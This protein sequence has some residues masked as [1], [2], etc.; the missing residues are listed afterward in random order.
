MSYSFLYYGII[1]GSWTSFGKLISS[2]SF[3]FYV[4]DTF[5][6]GKYGVAGVSGF[7]WTWD[8]M[9]DEAW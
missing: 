7:S 2:F 5:T 9:I 6:L 8:S 1:S 4:S 3:L